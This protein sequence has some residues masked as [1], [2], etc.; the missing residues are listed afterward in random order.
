VLDVIRSQKVQ[1]LVKNLI[2]NDGMMIMMDA[3]SI[4]VK[5]NNGVQMKIAVHVLYQKMTV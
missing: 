1:N 2:E 5:I 3:V 4:V